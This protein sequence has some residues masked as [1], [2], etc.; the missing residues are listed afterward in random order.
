MHPAINKMVV[1]VPPI[2]SVMPK[3]NFVCSAANAPITIPA[4][5]NSLIANADCA[6]RFIKKSMSFLLKNMA[7]RYKKNSTKLY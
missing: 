6:V 3:L 7:Q 1:I 5:A 4:K 2:S